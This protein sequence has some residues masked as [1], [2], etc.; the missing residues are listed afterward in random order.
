MSLLQFEET[1]IGDRRKA[2]PENGRL[3][4]RRQQCVHCHS[5]L[6]L[7]ITDKIGF[8][9]EY[10]VANDAIWLVGEPHLLYKKERWFGNFIRCP[11]C[12][13]E[14]RL[15]M[16]KPLSWENMQKSREGINA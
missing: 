11:V 7:E 2:L 4:I 3:T 15:P 10:Y 8:G 16:D 14:G 13:I 5:V 1:V 6:A 12:G 9:G